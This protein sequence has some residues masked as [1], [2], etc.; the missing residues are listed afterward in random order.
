MDGFVDA[1]PM[2]GAGV[3]AL[4]VGEEVVYVGKAKVLLTRIYSHRLT[5]KQFRSGQRVK[6]KAIFFNRLLI[7]P[8]KEMD[9]DRI[10]RQM[11]ATY[12]PRLNTNLLPKEKDLTFEKTGVDLN[13]LIGVITGRIPRPEV[14][15]AL[16]R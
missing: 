3:Y 12:R 6:A 1:G 9:L 2:L 11:I 16:R 8:C 14:Y 15:Q 13:N 5:Y 4:C 7:F 10:E